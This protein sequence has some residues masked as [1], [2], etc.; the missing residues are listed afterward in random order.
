MFA[1]SRCAASF[2]SAVDSTTRGTPRDLKNS[3]VA[4]RSSRPTPK[5]RCSRLTDALRLSRRM[6]YKNALAGLPLDGGKSI[7][8]APE[9]ILDREKLFRARAFCRD[10]QRSLHHRRGRRDNDRG[11]GIRLF[12]NEARS[13]NSLALRQSLACDGARC[14]SRHPR[15]L[16]FI[17][18]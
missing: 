11:H 6:T 13:R 18:S 10:A 16:W 1:K 3:S 2:R 17:D 12:G 9:K 7:I 15:L 5:P 8:M 14:L 4:S